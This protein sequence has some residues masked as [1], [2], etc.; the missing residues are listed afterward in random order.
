MMN[1]DPY[2][3]VILTDCDGVLL[4]WGYAF[5]V[6]MES[7]QGF[8]KRQEG[9]GSYSVADNYY[10]SK[11][12][13]KFHIKMFNKSAAIGFLPALRDAAYYVPKIHKELGYVFHCITS[14]YLTIGLHKDSENKIYK[15]YLVRLVLKRLFV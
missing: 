5:S 13:A 7:Q 9:W 1:K 3:K 11:E 2:N 15:R 8:E 4:N 12:H 6:Y 14:L 10:I